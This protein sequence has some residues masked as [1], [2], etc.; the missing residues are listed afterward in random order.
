M[1]VCGNRPCF[2]VYFYFESK[3]YKTK[4]M[5]CSR[6]KSVTCIHTKYMTCIHTKYMTGILDKF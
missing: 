6:T 3:L 4:N 5:T 1:C 2:C